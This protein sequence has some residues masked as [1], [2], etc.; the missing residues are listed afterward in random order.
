MSGVELLVLPEFCALP[1][2]PASG[3]LAYA[4]WAETLSDS[5]IVKILA[6]LAKRYRMAIA[7]T[8]Y[9]KDAVSGNRH[10]TA[11]YFNEEG[12]LQARVRRTPVGRANGFFEKLFLSESEE[13]PYRLLETRWG[14]LGLVLTRG[15]SFF[16]A[17]E[18]LVREGA[19]AILYPRAQLQGLSQAVI[20]QELRNHS[21]EWGYAL[22]CADRVGI[23]TYPGAEPLDWAGASF[24]LNRNGETLT[25][26]APRTAALLTADLALELED[27]ELVR[28]GAKLVTGLGAERIENGR[29]RSHGFENLH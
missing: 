27:D 19:S 11:V 18:Q 23:E 9:E 28:S 26:T 8:F 17:A 21:R 25:K 13:K 15:G 22:F 1:Y 5:K 3:D 14:R 6:I 10:S 16:S 7:G 29:D 2:F 12:E 24:I 20:D 4:E